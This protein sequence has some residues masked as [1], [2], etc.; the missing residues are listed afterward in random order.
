MKKKENKG[1]GNERK[2]GKRR[3]GKEGLGEG[4]GGKGKKN[5]G[6]EQREEGRRGKSWGLKIHMLRIKKPRQGKHFA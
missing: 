2:E 6:G 4:S 1:K 3:P 5:I